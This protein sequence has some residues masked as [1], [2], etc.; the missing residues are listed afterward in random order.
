MRQCPMKEDSD[1]S[2]RSETQPGGLHEAVS[3]CDRGF[4]DPRFGSGTIADHPCGSD[5][6]TAAS[7][8]IRRRTSQ[9]L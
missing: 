3:N 1:Q 5:E 7:W 6:E 4:W 9:R 8:F 2:P